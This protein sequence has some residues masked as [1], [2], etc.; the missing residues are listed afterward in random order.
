MKIVLEITQQVRDVTVI[1]KSCD[2][3]GFVEPFDNKKSQM[4]GILFEQQLPTGLKMRTDMT[5]DLIRR[6]PL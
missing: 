5:K 3:H 6:G 2:G 4:H 1:D